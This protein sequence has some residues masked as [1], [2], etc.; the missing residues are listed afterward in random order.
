[1]FLC[2]SRGIDGWHGASSRPFKLSNSIGQMRAR[3]EVDIELHWLGNTL[4]QQLS[5]CLSGCPTENFSDK[6]TEGVHVISVCRARRP[7][8]CLCRQSRGHHIPMKHCVIGQI[9]PYRWQACS[10]TQ[11]VA[12]CEH[13]F[14]VVGELGPHLRHT[15]VVGDFPT[16]HALCCN[17]RR[18]AFP[19]GEGVHEFVFTPC[20]GT[21]RDSRATP[22]IDDSTTFDFD[23]HR[24]TDFV[25]L[26][27]VVDEGITNC[28]E[29]GVARA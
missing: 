19:H 4:A 27:E 23:A 26:Y 10:M 21:R 17:D 14:A 22:Q 6:K 8:G 2:E 28:P 9:M 25:V 1:M 29:S 18:N 20:S 16:C 3:T 5:D 15:S 7:P 13:F 11:E 12:Q 24:S